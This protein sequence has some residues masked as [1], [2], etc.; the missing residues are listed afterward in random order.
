M[1]RGQDAITI[2]VSDTGPGIP[3]GMLDRLFI[4]F[5]RLGSENSLEQGAGLGLPLT[6]GSPR[7]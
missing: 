2:R 1:D 7:L 3:E 4:P 6:A 5:E